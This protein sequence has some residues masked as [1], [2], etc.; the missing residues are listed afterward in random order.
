MSGGAYDYL[1]F[2]LQ[3]IAKD[4]IVD[5]LHRAKERLIELGRPAIASKVGDILAGIAALEEQASK[6]TDVLY[7]LEWKDSGDWG[8]E[9]MNAE[10]DNYE[11]K[12]LITRTPLEY[13]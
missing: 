9:Q 12:H 7:A 4:G 8:D 1:Y 3:D 10:F 13:D 6:L 11:K 5:D 2:R